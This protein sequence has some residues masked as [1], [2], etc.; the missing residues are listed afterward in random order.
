MFRSY[1]IILAFL[2][3]ILPY[4]VGAEG[5]VDFQPH[6]KGKEVAFVKKYFYNICECK[7]LFVQGNLDM[8]YVEVGFY[9]VNDDGE[10][11]LFARIGGTGWTCGTSG[12]MTFIFEQKSGVWSFIGEMMVNSL[13]VSDEKIKGYR[14]LYSWPV[15]ARWGGEEYWAFDQAPEG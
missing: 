7:D 15:G 2:A 12:C 11:E 3:A 8:S 1:V 6:Y 10:A 14:T 9:D 4:P 5:Y 13:S